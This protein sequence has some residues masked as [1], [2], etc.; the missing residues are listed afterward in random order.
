V[1][2]ALAGDGPLKDPA[3]ATLPLAANV[4]LEFLG[5]FQYDDLP[6]IYS[7]AGSSFCRPWPILGPSWLTRLWSAGLPVLGSVY[8]QAVE[9][10]IQDG[11]NGWIFR[12]DNAEDTYRAIDRMMNTSELELDAMR[13]NG[14]TV[15]SQ[16]T[17][18]RVAD[19]IALAVNACVER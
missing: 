14:R 16:L 9:E 2:I 1:N 12:P 6:E 4:K 17:P 11:R 19:Q 10:L 15:A 3:F 18:E 7:S 5:V 8:A 13:A